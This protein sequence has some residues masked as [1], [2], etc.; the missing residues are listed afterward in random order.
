MFCPLQPSLI[1]IV[2]IPFS[3]QNVPQSSKSARCKASAAF[4]PHVGERH[5]FDFWPSDFVGEMM[6]LDIGVYRRSLFTCSIVGEIFDKLYPWLILQKHIQ[7]R[8][9][10][11]GTIAE[12]FMQAQAKWSGRR[13]S[14]RRH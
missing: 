3:D 7:R 14:E 8:L 5:C 1:F 12:S 4:C 9:N 11:L 2:L 6:D 13:S 10:S